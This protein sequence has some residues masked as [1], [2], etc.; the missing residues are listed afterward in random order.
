M[1]PHVR[2]GKA[3]WEQH[4]ITSFPFWVIYYFPE[5]SYMVWS[6]WGHRLHWKDGLLPSLFCRSTAPAM[7]KAKGSSEEMFSHSFI[8]LCSWVWWLPKSDSSLN[9][10]QGIQLCTFSRSVMHI[11]ISLAFSQIFS[12]IKRE[13]NI[14]FALLQSLLNTNF[15]S[16]IAPSATAPVPVF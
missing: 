2:L 14:C 3:W 12:K 1:A 6:N 10:S 9:E 8:A 13:M 7:W 5:D 4:L 16:R 15:F 11:C